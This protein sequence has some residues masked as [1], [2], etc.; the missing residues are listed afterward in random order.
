MDLFIHIDKQN[1][2]R[3]IRVIVKDY[4]LFIIKDSQF[5]LEII[6]IKFIGFFSS[7]VESL[8]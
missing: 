5:L 6:T 2:K 1:F 8:I 3:N 4:E 7:R